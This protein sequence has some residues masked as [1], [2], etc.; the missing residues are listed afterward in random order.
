MASFRRHVF[1][2]YKLALKALQL[3]NATSCQYLHDTCKDMKRMIDQTLRMVEL[4]KPYIFFEGE[5]DDSN[6]ERLRTTIS[7]NEVEENAFFC[8]PKC[9]DWN[10][11]FMNIHFPGLV[12][13]VIKL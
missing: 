4:N 1:L 12:K 2:N 3:V 13:Y 9:I 8:D 10:D 5:F 7:A 11:Y 6:T